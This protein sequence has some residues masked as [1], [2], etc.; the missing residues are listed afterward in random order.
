MFRDL[1][2]LCEET[3]QPAQRAR[4]GGAVPDHGRPARR[5]ASSRCSGPW[6]RRLTGNSLPSARR[7]TQWELVHR[8][9]QQMG[10][11]ADVEQRVARSRRWPRSSR[12]RRRRSPRSA[13]RT[14]HHDLLWL[15]AFVGGQRTLAAAL[16]VDRCLLQRCPEA[17][18]SEVELSIMTGAYPI[19]GAGTGRGRTRVCAV[20]KSS[21]REGATDAIHSIL[22]RGQ[23]PRFP[24]APTVQSVALPRAGWLAVSANSAIRLCAIR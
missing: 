22:R 13:G 24:S 3:L 15:V 18:D 16:L 4:P 21:T 12:S 2:A 5:S 17:G 10:F 6:R 14:V 8:L 9:A 7:S 19:P 11:A 1:Q 20:T 23:P